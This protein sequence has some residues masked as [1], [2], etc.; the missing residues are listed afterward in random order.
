VNILEYL[1]AF[2]ALHSG[3]IQCLSVQF[4]LYSLQNEISQRSVA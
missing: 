4:S 1:N 3:A 2:V